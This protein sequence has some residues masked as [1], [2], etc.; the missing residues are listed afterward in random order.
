MVRLWASRSRASS[1]ARV[2]GAL[3]S[4][5]GVVAQE[6][7]VHDRIAHQHQLQ[8]LVAIGID[9]TDQIPHQ[10]AEGAAD[11]TG[12][13]CFAA[14]VHHHVGDPAHQ[15]FAEADLRVHGSGGGQDLAGG[16]VAQVPSDRG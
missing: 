5:V 2:N 8:H 9:L 10:I 14:R 6:Q 13:L 4:G 16:Q 3:P 1:T 12:Q 15:V 11:R 7:V